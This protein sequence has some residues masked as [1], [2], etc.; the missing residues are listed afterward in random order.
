MSEIKFSTHTEPQAKL[1]SCVYNHYVFGRQMRR[2]GQRHKQEQEQEQEGLQ[3]V[4]LFPWKLSR[5]D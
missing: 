5:N 2:Q 1:E 3:G 4:L